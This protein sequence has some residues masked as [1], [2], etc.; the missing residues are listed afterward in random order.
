M[1]ICARGIQPKKKRW[2][3]LLT[4]VLF[5]VTPSAPPSHRP[6]FSQFYAVFRKCWWNYMLATRAGGLAPPS[7]EILDP[8]LPEEAQAVQTQEV[9]RPGGDFWRVD[10]ATYGWVYLLHCDVEAKIIVFRWPRLLESK[11]SNCCYSEVRLFT[12]VRG[13]FV[14]IRWSPNPQVFPWTVIVI[15]WA[16]K[17]SPD[18][19]WTAIVI[20][21]PGIWL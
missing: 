8:S 19:K 4:I 6:N 13:L 11:S 9:S 18:L 20:I 2:G 15:F 3:W 16:R 14:A 21:R 7:T 17:P 1:D 5:K 10:S 12:D